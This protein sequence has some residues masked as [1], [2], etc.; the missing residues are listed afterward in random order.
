[1]T[2]RNAAEEDF[3]G[4]LKRLVSNRHAAALTL[5]ACA[6]PARA[7]KFASSWLQSQAPRSTPLPRAEDDQGGLTWAA[8]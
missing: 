6:G 5:V 1:M 8:R 3:R 2:A 4:V 7:R